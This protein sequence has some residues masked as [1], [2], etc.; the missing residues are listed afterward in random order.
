MLLEQGQEVRSFP[1]GTLALASAV[2]N[3]P[4]LILLDIN[5]A[6]MNGYEVC[7]RRP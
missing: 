6:E 1:L 5:M 3:P 4:A 2:K 7:Q